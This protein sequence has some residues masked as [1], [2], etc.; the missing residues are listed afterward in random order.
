M[1]LK[2]DEVRFLVATIGKYFPSPEFQVLLFGSFA[3]G[4]ARKNS[5]VDIAI[6]GVGPL[7]PVLWQNL[8]TELEESSFSRAVDIVDY[9]RVSDDFKKIIDRDGIPMES[10]R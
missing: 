10:L 2:S 5:D 6:K 1:N 3:V 4:R 7:S 9:H 8:E